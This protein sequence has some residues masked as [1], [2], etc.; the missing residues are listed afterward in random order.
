MQES[1]RRPTRHR[2]LAK[3]G[4]RKRRERALEWLRLEEVVEPVGGRDRQRAQQ[5]DHATAPEA[6][7]SATE[8]EQR[9]E[10]VD[11]S[12]VDAR[13]GVAK[14]RREKAREGR[15]LLHELRPALGVA[16]GNTPQG[17]GGLNCGALQRERSALAESDDGRIG[18]NARMDLGHAAECLRVEVTEVGHQWGGA[19][20]GREFDLAIDPPEIGARLEQQDTHAGRGEPGRRHQRIRLAAEDYHIEGATHVS[21]RIRCAAR[22]PAAPITPPPGC[23][24]EPHW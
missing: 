1:Q 12:S 20:A 16:R 4:D 6:A 11:R 13:R 9:E 10:F 2:S 22:R 14:Q 17:R 5:L 7:V 23:V 3:V 18:C 19:P 8:P 21:D 15:E 24:L